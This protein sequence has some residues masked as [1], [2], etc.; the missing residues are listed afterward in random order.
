[1]ARWCVFGVVRDKTLLRERASEGDDDGS[2]WGGEETDGLGQKVVAGTDGQD[3]YA[4][5]AR[6]GRALADQ[7]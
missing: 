7:A 4:V 3:G 1:M 6:N 2:G 5:R